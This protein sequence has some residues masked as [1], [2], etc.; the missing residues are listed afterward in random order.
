[1]RKVL[2]I[3]VVVLSV[4]LAF[5][6]FSLAAPLPDIPEQEFALVEPAS[7]LEISAADERCGEYFIRTSPL[8]ESDGRSRLRFAF[9]LNDSRGE[10]VVASMRFLPDKLTVYLDDSKK[11]PSIFVRGA[12]AE[13]FAVFLSISRRDF[14]RSTCLPRPVKRPSLSRERIV[15]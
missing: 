12:T 14:G 8:N 7:V 1:M 11:V 3:I 15:G 10:R 9:V 13:V 5:F 2:S 6:A 4:V